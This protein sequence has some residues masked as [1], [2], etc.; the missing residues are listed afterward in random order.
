[1]VN[2]K[3]NNALI[4]RALTECMGLAK[5]VIESVYAI[6]SGE[7]DELQVVCFQTFGDV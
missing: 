5:L 2:K 3:R 1:L 6:I 4:P 7:I